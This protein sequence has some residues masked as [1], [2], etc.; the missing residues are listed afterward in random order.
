LILDRAGR[1]SEELLPKIETALERIRQIEDESIFPVL[2]TIPVQG[3][4]I[5]MIPLSPTPCQVMKNKKQQTQ[6]LRI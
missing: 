1:T 6:A 2:I 5:P 4:K 3:L